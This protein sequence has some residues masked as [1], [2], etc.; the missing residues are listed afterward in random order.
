MK[1][2]YGR[3]ARSALE[4]AKIEMASGDIHR[5]RYAALELRMALECVTYE[6]AQLYESEIH[7]D[8]YRTWQPGKLLDVLLEIEPDV[9]RSVI[10][11]VRRD[12]SETTPAGDYVELGDDTVIPLKTVKSLYHALGNFLHIA[13]MAQLIDGQEFNERRARAKCEEVV[14]ALEKTLASKLRVTFGEFR[15]FQCINCDSLIRRRVG[16]DGETVVAKCHSCIATYDLVKIPDNDWQALANKSSITCVQD[17]CKNIFTVWTSELKVGGIWHCPACETSMK[18]G[19]KI[20]A[21]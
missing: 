8:E 11:R 1:Y 7:P 6:R 20:S 18:V 9:N 13:T 21:I 17:E 14:A 16:L 19:L 10:V 12:A 5:L 3:G 15:S 4:R 2:Q